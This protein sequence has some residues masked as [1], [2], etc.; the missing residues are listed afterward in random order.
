MVRA[1]YRQSKGKFKFHNM[2]PKNSLSSPDCVIRAIS[3]ATEKTWDEMYIGLCEVGLKLKD[4]PN[5]SKVYEKYMKNLGYDKQKQPRKEDGKKYTVNEFCE[6]HPKGNYVCK[7][8]KH[9][10]V[11][12]DGFFEDTWD[13]GSKT[14][15]NFWKIK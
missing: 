12:K 1:S 2:N 3:N 15:G 7:I 8:A 6:L 10:T 11:V 4:V 13:C 9:V 14:V 5:S